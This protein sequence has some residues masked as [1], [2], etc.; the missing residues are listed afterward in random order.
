MTA[1]NLDVIAAL[2][3]SFAVVI[4]AAVF[5]DRRVNRRRNVIELPQRPVSNVVALNAEK[6]R[7]I[8]IRTGERGGAA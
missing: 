5:V 8:Q 2:L 1:H 6:A 3:V 7:V 4:P